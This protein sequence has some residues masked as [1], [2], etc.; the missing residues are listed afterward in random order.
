MQKPGDDP[1]RG[2]ASVRGVAYWTDDGSDTRIFTYRNQFLYA[3]DPKTGEVIPSFGTGGRVDLALGLD[4]LAGGWSWN[5]APLIVRDV[6]VIGSAMVDQDF[7][8][9]MEGAPGVVRAFDVRT[10]ELR[11]TWSP[12]PRTG[13]PGVDTWENESWAYTGA[14]NVWSMMS[15]DDE[16]G[17]VY[18]PTTSVTNDMYGGHRLGDNLYSTSVVCLDAATGKRVWHFQTVHHDLFDYDNPAAPILADITRQRTADQGGRAGHEAVVR[19]R[20][21]IASPA[22]R[23]GRSKRRPVPASTVPG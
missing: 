11:W 6:V 16:L 15:A 22:S 23:C 5:G 3:L 2:S 8:T 21:A 18:L 4:P 13:E 10:G 20:A 7:A 14:A 12:I 9:K 17:Y 1:L 19:L